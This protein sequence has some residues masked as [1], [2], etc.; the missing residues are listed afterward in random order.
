MVR[1]LSLL[2]V[3][4]FFALFIFPDVT[5]AS[6]GLIPP[7][8]KLYFLQTLG[9]SVKLYFTRGPQQKFDYLLGLTER[10]VDEAKLS[11]DSQVLSRYQ[12]QMNEAATLAADLP[13]RDTA[14]QRITDASLRQQ[15]VLAQ[16]YMRVPDEAK[17]AILGAQT[18]SSKHVANTIQAVGGLKRAEDYN[19][20]VQVIL[21]AEQIGQV[22]QVQMEGP[23]NGNPSD[24]NINPINDGRGL[25]Q[26]NPINDQNG[27]AGIQPAAPIQMK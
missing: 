3:I 26:L 1:K 27:G 18:E 21:R 25:N 20:K 7:T 16:V 12:S 13:G 24:K 9:E 2:F 23:P 22:E 8:S 4:F 11:A 15:A 10:R 14:V 5:R 6:A 17:G 19:K